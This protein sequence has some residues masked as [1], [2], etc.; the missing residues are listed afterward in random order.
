[1]VMC[2]VK[3]C[4][5][6]SK[7]YSTI[8]FHRIPTKNKK[9]KNQWLAALNIDLKT[10]VESIKKWRV[11]SEHFGPDDYLENMDSVTRTTV[12]RL[13]DTTIPTIF[14]LYSSSPQPMQSDGTRAEIMFMDELMIY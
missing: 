10:P 8:M 1:M 3:G 9:R 5:S 12:R 6:K 4:D 14:R 2:V 11:C 13:K 7:V